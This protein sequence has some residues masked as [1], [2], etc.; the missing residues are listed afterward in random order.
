M[1]NDGEQKRGFGESGSGNPVFPEARPVKQIVEEGL[2]E[3]PKFQP[4]EIGP[5]IAETPTENQFGTPHLSYPQAAKLVEKNEYDTILEGNEFPTDSNEYDAFLA[6]NKEEQKV[7]MQRAMF[8][9][10]QTT[11]DRAAEI[12][13][14]SNKMKVPTSFVARNFDLLSKKEG[15]S[16]TDYDRIIRKTPSLAKWLNN[17][18]NASVAKDDIDGLS[19]IEETV[20]DHG[21]FS[22]VY[23]DLATGAAGLNNFMLQLPAL[24]YDVANYIPN[25]AYKAAGLPQVRSPEWLR[26]NFATQYWKKAKQDFSIPELSVDVSDEAKRGNYSVASKAMFHQL[27]ANTPQLGA[28]LALSFTPAG[29]AATTTGGFVMGAANANESAQASGVEPVAAT[30]DSILHGTFEAAFERLGLNRILKGWDHA[31]TKN[32]G[33][34]ASKEV[35]KDF[36]KVIASSYFTEGTEEQ[37]TTIAQ[38]FSDYITGV[39]PDAMKGTLGRSAN[40]FLLGGFSGVGLTSPAAILHSH[41]RNQQNKQVQLNKDFYNALGEA[42]SGTKLKERLPEKQKELVEQITK[43]TPVENI[44]ISAEAVETYFQTKNVNPV[45]AM[46]ELGAL[47]AYEE[48]KTTGEDLKIPL[49]TWVDKF[50]GTE[51]YQALADDIKFSDSGQSVN[52]AKAQREALEEEAKKASSDPKIEQETKAIKET[53]K[54]QLIEAGRPGTEADKVADLNSRFFRTQAVRTGRGAQELFDQFGL[55]FN[56]P[57]LKPVAE[58][59]LEILDDDALVLNQDQVKAPP[60]FSKLQQTVEQKMGNSA[61]VEQVTALTRELKPE[62]VEWSGL[63]EFLKGKEKVSKAELLEHLRANELQI[64]EVVKG[65]TAEADERFIQDLMVEEGIS[66]EEAERAYRDFY[67]PERQDIPVSETK[68]SKYTLPGGENY[69]EMLFT[70]PQRQGEAYQHWQSYI[71]E[72]K[73]KYGEGFYNSGKLKKKEKERLEALHRL[74][75]NGAGES[76]LNYQSSHFDEPNVLA[77]TRV[78]DRVDSEGKKVLFIEEI[79]SDWHQKGRKKGYKAGSADDLRSESNKVFYKMNTMERDGNQGSPEYLKL[80]TRFK[81]LE[82]EILEIEQHPSGV[83]NAPFKKTWHEFVLKRMIREAAEKGYDKI[84]WTTGEQQ[85]ERYDLSKQVDR[86]VYRK[87]KDGNYDIAI[88][89]STPGGGSGQINTGKNTYSESE[90]EGLVGKEVSQKI[91]DGTGRKAGANKVLKGVDL[92]IGGEG[93]KGFYDKILVDAA[94]KLT[95]K[96]GGRVN[97]T[98]YETLQNDKV[99]SLEITPELRKTALEQGFSL[100][101]GDNI[102]PRGSIEI[103]PGKSLKISLFNSADAS[104]AIH[105]LGHAYFD[106]LG[107]LA[108]QENANEQIKKDYQS[109]LDWLQ[110]KNGEKISVDQQEQL[111]RGFEAYVREGKAPSQGL[112]RIFSSF[113]VWLTNIY[114]NVKALNVELS[115]DVRAVFDRMVATED[116]IASAEVMQYQHPLFLDPVAAGMTETQAAR[117]IAARDAARDASEEELQT[118]L[119]KELERKQSKEYKEK[120]AAVREQV[121]FEFD[122]APIYKTIDLLRSDEPIEGADVL[123]LDKSQVPDGYKLPKGITAEEGL[124]P[125]VAASLLGFDSGKQM[126]D[127]LAEAPKKEEAIDQAV[128]QRMQELYPEL[129]NTP[130]IDQEAMQAIH[131]EKRAQ[132]LRMELEHLASNNL[133][134]LK[135]VIRKVSRRVPTE[136]SVRRQAEEIIASKNIE[137][138]RP[139]TFQRAEAKAA[140]EAGALLAQ[141]N[142]D[143]AFQAKQRELLNHELYRAAVKANEDID[144]SIERWKRIAKNDADI[145]KGRDINYVDAARAILAAHGLGKTEK[146]AIEYL[147]N[148]KAYD[149]EGYNSIAELIEALAPNP[150]DYSELS[151][152][153]FVDV[154]NTIDA[155]WSLAKTEKEQL[156][157]GQKVQQDKI[158]GEL[159]ARTSEID[160]TPRE[161]KRYLKSSDN[162]DKFKSRLLGMRASLR[163]VESW[164]DLMGAPFTKYIFEPVSEA[165]TQYR[166]Q[167]EIYIKKF[168]EI[169]KPIEKT[170]TRAPIYADELRDLGGQAYQFSGRGELLGMLLHRGNE[171]NFS[172]LLRG[173][174]WSQESFNSFEQRM[175]A[176]GKL[177]KQDYDIIQSIWDLNEEL[178]PQAQKAHKAMYGYYFNEITANEFETPWGTYRG[179]YAPAIADPL[180][181]PDAKIRNEKDQIEKSNNSFMFPTTGRGFTKGRV[182]AYAA[183]LMMDLK[184]IPQHLDKVLRFINIEPRV[185][186][187]GR[188]LWNKELRGA[189]DSFDSGVVGDMLIPWLQRAAQQMVEEPLKGDGGKAIDWFF[190]A[191]RKN[192]GMQLMV[193][194]VVNTLQNFTGFSIAATKVK[195]KYLRNSLFQFMKAPKEMN[196]DISEK[197]DFMKTRTATQIFDIQK[198][199]DDVLINPTKYEKV[200]D[201]ITEH[202]YILQR[203]S[204]NMID[205]VVWS[206]AYDQAVEQNLSEKEAVKAA[207]SAVRTTQG[208]FNP[209][210]V[211]RYESGPSFVR[212]FTMFA[213]YFNMQANLLGTEFGKVIRDMGLKKGYG[214]AFYIYAMGFMIPAVLGQLLVQAGGGKFDEDDDDDYLNDFMDAFFQGQLRAASALAFGVG[215]IIMSGI[216]SFNNKWYDDRIQSSPAAS[217]LESAARAPSSI[218]KAIAEDGSKKKAIQDA[219]TLLGL[220]SG[221]PVAPLARPLGYLADVSEGKAEPTG[222]IDFLRGITTGKSG[223]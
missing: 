168:L 184:F 182:D 78:N 111:A 145:A 47:K 124:H 131:N 108:S 100:F 10:D 67:L 94:N 9:A 122:N 93:M 215:P 171:S 161:K 96:F 158:I 55:M 188:L 66:R 178:K 183:P 138:I 212:A 1:A 206:G 97:S 172:K 163:R 37:L 151:Y 42:A 205:N 162:W 119:M 105:E 165:V 156:I 57:N 120:E 113:K 139:A 223:R 221:L 28:L 195:P 77:H 6:K 73:A 193:G 130:E 5:V 176:E 53:I 2:T 214:R 170:L 141:G 173:R 48:A 32:I 159:T 211:S 95:K 143:G 49:S 61:T 129:M 15:A 3:A 102:S 220:M 175:W 11:P 191:V 117:Y 65:T 150:K 112:R 210:D 90:L 133:P 116:E 64:K 4:T 128:G 146:P 12:T 91:I 43:G 203:L 27:M 41:L 52:E 190:R 92:K 69:R 45:S 36:T 103:A 34:A 127:A 135:D 216:N 79:Q 68:F 166:I 157:D 54:S 21:F 20:N 98:D 16:T 86:I 104:T 148:L 160:Q 38:D 114:R 50:V 154:K 17:P 81:Q 204:Q 153:E 31:L 62:E 56:N 197:S 164:A 109:L 207:D 84:A 149:P 60:F 72:L 213:S 88:M 174:G 35:F 136:Q 140:K 70:L 196:A 198:R 76:D 89:Q 144:K 33:K 194:N 40:S 126:L 132:L 121:Q 87:L 30:T 82:A 181:A 189:L 110:V 118:K 46:Q 59:Q 186:E 71:A 14:L 58:D 222:P 137:D 180:A 169:I 39:N 123:K 80:E 99:H 8:V 18:D 115:D 185:K 217:A 74:A 155:L 134:V 218:Y 22:K 202:G 209:E 13:R 44:H 192:T 24:T 177:N 187:V 101:Q 75:G 200:K 23:L 219:F 51:H 147:R 63:N 179:G 25:I 199:I 167:K 125:D 201:F 19:K 83:P 26:N 107:N 7:G 142:I 152:N 208:S 106:I 29:L 85:A